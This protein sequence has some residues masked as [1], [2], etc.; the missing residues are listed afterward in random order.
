MC[1]LSLVGYVCELGYAA[2]KNVLCH[3]VELMGHAQV[4]TQAMKMI[5]VIAMLRV[6]V[7][8]HPIV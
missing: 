7:S 3:L 5:L 6:P 2:W 1:T 8:H 4:D